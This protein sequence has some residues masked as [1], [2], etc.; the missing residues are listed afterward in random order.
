MQPSPTSPPRSPAKG[1]RSTIDGRSARALRT[2]EAIV[3]ACI[4]LVE[5]GELRPTAPRVAERAGV[6]VRSVF[7]HFADLPALH[8]AVTER[9][10]ERV[11]VLLHPIDPDMPLDERL[12]AFVRHRAALLEAVTPFRRAANVHGPFAPEIQ[13]ALRLATDYLRD[14]VARAF[15]PE[16]ARVPARDR[17]E[18][19]DGLSTAL[20]WS[21]WDAL[22]TDAGCSVEHASAV[23]TRMVTALLV[24]ARVSR[25]S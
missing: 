9:I 14:E 1:A 22:R 12:P 7:Q 16:L 18:V 13:E 6:S 24:A 10:V 11:A 4:G 17:Q 2:R 21:A 15:E 25:G 20:S 5:E 3:D 19:L 23:T 8:I